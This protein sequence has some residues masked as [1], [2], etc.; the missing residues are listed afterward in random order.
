MNVKLK[1]STDEQISAYLAKN[2]KILLSNEAAKI[3]EAAKS[4]LN[5][6]LCGRPVFSKSDASKAFSSL[7]NKKIDSDDIVVLM[8]KPNRIPDMP[9]FAYNMD[10]RG[11]LFIKDGE[12]DIF[13]VDDAMHRFDPDEGEIS[14]KDTWKMYFWGIIIAGIITALMLTLF[15]R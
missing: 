1:P 14:S 9:S 8:G 13:F 10:N 15:P 3:R 12:R 5:L 6:Y 2:Q 11:W 7:L 4:P